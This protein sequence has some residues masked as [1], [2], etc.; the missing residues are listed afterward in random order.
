MRVVSVLTLALLAFPCSGSKC[1]AATP[2]ATHPSE[3]DRARQ[4]V[5]NLA[6]PD[7]EVRHR[8][9]LQLNSLGADAMEV[10][11]AAAKNDPTPERQIRLRRSLQFLRARALVERR[12]QTRLKWELQQFLDAYDHAGHTGAAWDAAAKRGIELYL[13]LGLDPQH[14]PPAARNAALA[15]FKVRKNPSAASGFMERLLSVISPKVAQAVGKRVQ[16]FGEGLNTV[17]DV[18]SFFQLAGLSIIIWAVIGFAYMSVTHAYSIHRLSQMTLSSVFLLTAA[19]VVGGVLQLPVV[20]GGSQLATIGMLRSGEINFLADYGGDPE[21]LEQ[22]ARQ[23]PAIQVANET[24]IGF[25]FVAFNNRRAPFN[26]PAFRRALSAALDRNTMVQA[27]WNG[28]A[29]SANSHVSPALRYWHS[30][31][32]DNMRT[33]IPVARDILTQAGYRVVDG[34]LRYPTGRTESLQPGE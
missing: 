1:L 4:V 26:D 25:E 3:A 5:R 24:D 17:K 16:A 29:V 33:G 31:A 9:T 8:A 11:E 32:V 15:A 27:A 10:I 14:G 12:L 22:L 28:F 21:V 19:S 18:G 23:V 30:E 2:P 13:T 6:D 20:G 34:R 7:P